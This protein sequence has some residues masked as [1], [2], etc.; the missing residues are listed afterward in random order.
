[1]AWVGDTLDS[2]FWKDGVELKNPEKDTNKK[3]AEELQKATITDKSNRTT[4][5]EV[6]NPEDGKL[7]VKFKDNSIL[8]VTQKLYVYKNGSEKPNVPNPPTAKDSVEVTYK[9]GTGVKPFDDKVVFVKKNT[10]E[11][12]LPGKPN[13]TVDTKNGYKGEVIWTAEPAIDETNGIQ[14]NTTVTATAEK[15]TT[16]EIIEEAGGLKGK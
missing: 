3:L 12:E 7:E 5:D 9:K 13:A 10:K 1:A 6:L 15:K 14:K 11:K 16:K 2:D 8:E 4:A